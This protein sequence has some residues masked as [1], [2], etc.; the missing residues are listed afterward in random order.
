[1]PDLFRGI[2]FPFRRGTTSFPAAASGAALI[3][4]S[5]RTLVMT[6]RGDRVM[7]PD[8]GSG[9]Y[10]YIF[11]TNDPMLEET[12]RTDVSQTLGRYEP[13]IIVQSVEVVPDSDKGI[14]DVTI[15]YVIRAT[16]TPDSV[17]TTF[18]R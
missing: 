14:V 3:Q 16:G 1:M 15:N 7:R 11:E 4:D 18:T 5:V 2:G 6:R 8:V 9:A 17:T 10:D 12:I 13:R